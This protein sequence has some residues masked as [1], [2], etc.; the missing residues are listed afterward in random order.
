MYLNLYL[1]SKGYFEKIKFASHAYHLHPSQACI[2]SPS[3]FTQWG[4]SN[5]TIYGNTFRVLSKA[6]ENKCDVFIYFL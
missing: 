3:H 6:R 5:I 1:N 2:W 4:Y